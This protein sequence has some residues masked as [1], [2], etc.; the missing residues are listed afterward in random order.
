MIFFYIGLGIVICYTLFM[1]VKTK[2][3]PDSISDTYYEGA[4]NWFTI[5]M[6]VASLLLIIGMLD[7]SEGS[8]WQFVSFFTGAGMALV[9]AAP[10]FK[11]GERVIHYLGAS[12]LLVGSQMWLLL[13]GNPLAL[14][15]WISIPLWWKSK[16]RIFWCEIICLLNVLLGIV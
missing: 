16:Q 15:V 11:T 12:V 9:G 2:H 4:G 7:I 6:F 1:I 3:I 13:F 8:Y 5:I 14:L 10:K